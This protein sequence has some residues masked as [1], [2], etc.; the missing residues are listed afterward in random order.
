MSSE[1]TIDGVVAGR[2]RG[3]GRLVGTATT[4]DGAVVVRIED[5]ADPAAWIELDLSINIIVQ[6]ETARLNAE[7]GEID[8]NEP[9]DSMPW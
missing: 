2:L 3:R 6:A 8:L 5:D 4:R 7:D 1:L 9:C